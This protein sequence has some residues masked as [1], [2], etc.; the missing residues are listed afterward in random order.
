MGLF[1]KVVAVCG[2][3]AV[4]A[5]A[6]MLIAE[7]AAFFAGYVVSV[8]LLTSLR[9]TVHQAYIVANTKPSARLQ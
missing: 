4:V 3:V 9:R 5:F 8:A 7:R 1:Y 2:G 6:V